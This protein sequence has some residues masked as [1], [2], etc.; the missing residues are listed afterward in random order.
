MEEKTEM[1]EKQ[2]TN[3]EPVEEPK[4]KKKNGYI[5]RVYDWVLHWAET[6]YG[7]WALFILA[8]AESSF[9]PIPPDIL[10]IALA[11]SIPTKAFRYALVC[12]FGSILGGIFGYYIGA[13][14]MGSVGQP[15]IDYYGAQ[16]YFDKVAGMYK[17]HEFWAVSAAGFTPIPY[18]VFTITG[19]ACGIN[20]VTFIIASTLSR[21][22]RFFIVAGLIYKFGPSIKTFIDKYFNVLSILFLIVLVLGFLLVKWIF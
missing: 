6:P 17:E 19:G 12:S 22:A 15:L 13:Q 3:T 8:F 4:T 10:L 20:L 11:I 9:F 5:R 18:K 1:L 2:P 21:S 16:H 7:V 14:L